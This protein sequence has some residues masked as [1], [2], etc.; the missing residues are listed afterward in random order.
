MMTAKQCF[1]QL[2][3][4]S[5][6]RHQGVFT[7]AEKYISQVPISDIRQLRDKVRE[8]PPSQFTTDVVDLLNARLAHQ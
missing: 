5:K 4:L 7:L 6:T 2:E 3:V 8:L 1:K